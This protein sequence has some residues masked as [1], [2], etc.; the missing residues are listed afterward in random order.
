VSSPRK[1]Q[2]SRMAGSGW[3]SAAALAT[4]AAKRAELGNPVLTKDEVTDRKLTG[5][6]LLVIENMVRPNFSMASYFP[7][8]PAEPLG[9]PPGLLRR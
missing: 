3:I 1:T 7:I 2:A 8:S 4:I 5:E 9:R 6:H